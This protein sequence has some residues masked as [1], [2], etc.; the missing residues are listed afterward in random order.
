MT[1]K[2]YLTENEVIKGIVNYLTNKG[3]T[4]KH[5]VV[6][7]ADA[8]KKEHGTDL[9]MHLAN[10][11]GNGNY[12]Y[13]EAKGNLTSGGQTTTVNFLTNF[14]WAVSE[15]ILR[16]TSPSNKNNRI[17]GIGIPNSEYERCVKLV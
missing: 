11:A 4:T 15:I 5:K 16:I 14:R 17:Y 6:R 3:K 1:N 13:I 7:M 2:Q 8:E 10:D 9:V 12:Y